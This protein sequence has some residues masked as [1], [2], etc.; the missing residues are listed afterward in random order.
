MQ[1]VMAKRSDSER[2]ADGIVRGITGL[3]DLMQYLEEPHADD[4]SDL[5]ELG[6]DTASR[7]R[8]AI[9]YLGGLEE[10]E[11]AD[12]AGVMEAESN[13]WLELSYLLRY[14][15]GSTEAEV[16]SATAL[17]AFGGPNAWAKVYPSGE[18][19]VIVKWWGDDATARVYAPRYA[20]WIIDT[21]EAGL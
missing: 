17:M 5:E 2:Y 16:D 21:V 3:E 13:N 20:G 15:V 7:I 4:L 10:L 6:P 8:E 9:D 19:E 12:T 14:T 11:S 18:V 1:G